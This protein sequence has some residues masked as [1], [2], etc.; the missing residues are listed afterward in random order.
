M[1]D[2][3]SLPPKP[4]APKKNIPNQPNLDTIVEDIPSRPPKPTAPK[5]RSSST[6]AKP[7]IQPPK[8]YDDDNGD[9]APPPKPLKPKKMGNDIHST[10]ASGASNIK[11]NPQSNTPKRGG[12]HRD[13]GTPPSRGDV[14]QRGNL[15]PRGNTISTPNPNPGP[16]R[17][18]SNNNRG[19]GAPRGRGGPPRGGM[20][21]DKSVVT[22]NMDQN[23]QDNTNEETVPPPAMRGNK[24]RGGQ[25]RR[26]LPGGRG[27]A[28]RGRGGLVRSNTDS[29]IKKE[30]NDETRN[31]SKSQSNEVKQAI[32]KDVPGLGRLS[33]LVKPTQ[34]ARTT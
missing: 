33:A 25:Q 32:S 27:N 28:N 30:K 26:V 21:G 7:I 10:P 1:E 19:R 8:K 5:K 11:I 3:P 17:G 23:T 22:N 14:V 13:R 20:G 6:P 31:L 9:N 2:M 12:S 18:V 16:Q 15:T 4:M 24:N 34:V 29:A